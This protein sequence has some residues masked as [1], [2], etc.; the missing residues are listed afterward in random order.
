MASGLYPPQ[1]RSEHGQD[2][3]DRRVADA[4]SRKSATALRLAAHTM[5]IRI[6]ATPTAM[7]SSVP[8]RH[9]VVYNLVGLFFG[10]LRSPDAVQKSRPRRRP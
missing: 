8:W 2:L 3:I 4:C 7:K 9:H 1:H 6:P 5:G 10:Y